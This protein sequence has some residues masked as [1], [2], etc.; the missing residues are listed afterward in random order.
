M[1]VAT[2]DRGEK[3]SE[4]C[5]MAMTRFEK[6]FVNRR[7]KTE[8]NIETVQN[9]LHSLNIQNIHDVLE[10]GCGIGALSAFLSSEYG[11]NVHATDFDPAQIQIARELYKEGDRLHFHIED[12]AKLTFED[13]SFDLVLSQNVF[14]HIAVWP[15]A[16]RE[17]ARVLR[18]DGHLIWIDMVFPRVITKLFKPLAKTYGLYTFD[19]IWLELW[20]NGF[21]ERVHERQL[22]GPFS[23]HHFIMQKACSTAQS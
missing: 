6:L 8:R 21:D 15:Q 14:H 2:L 16:V 1:L 9:R 11:M 18:V 5:P 17:I 22:H 20:D 4:E 7:E 12:A 10:I 13:A 19:D 23:Y 3:I